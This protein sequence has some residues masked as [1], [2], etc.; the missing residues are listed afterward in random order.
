MG[1]FFCL[2]DFSHFVSFISL[3]FLHVC[4]FLCVYV[5]F[6]FIISLGDFSVF[7]FLFDVF[8]FLSLLCCV[9]CRVLVLHP[10]IGPESLRWENQVQ[11]VGP[12]GNS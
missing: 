8:L 10:G 5:W 2:F 4:L 1:L 11:E 6:S 3:L 12:P 9:A 7:A